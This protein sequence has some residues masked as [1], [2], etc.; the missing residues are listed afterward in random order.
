MPR[1][2]KWPED[3]EQ[4]RFEAIALFARVKAEIDLAFEAMSRG[5][6]NGAA[7]H[8]GRA[9]G[10]AAK[11]RYLLWRLPEMSVYDGGEAEDWG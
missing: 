8:M 9:K 5:D 7:R 11:G 1:R 3:A 6:P 2:R 10:A 4:Q